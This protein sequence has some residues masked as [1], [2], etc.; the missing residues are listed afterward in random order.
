MSQLL[1][2]RIHSYITDGLP[3]EHPLANKMV[4]CGYCGKTVHAFNNEC[5]SPW[6]E[7]GVSEYCL[8]CFA[9]IDLLT[10]RHG[11]TS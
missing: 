4:E 5:M 2:P 1:E 11:L 7:T 9:S 8:Q 6:V 10:D 3:E